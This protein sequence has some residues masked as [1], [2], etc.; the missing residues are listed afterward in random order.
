MSYDYPR[1][2]IPNKLYNSTKN[3]WL[4]CKN[5][6]MEKWNFMIWVGGELEVC[7]RG[8]TDHNSKK[9]KEN[10]YILIYA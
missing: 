10:K 8:D 1:K 5:M 7:Q 4:K 2:K 6:L 9:T 3:V